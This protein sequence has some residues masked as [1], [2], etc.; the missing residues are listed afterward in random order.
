MIIT[1]PAIAFIML[2]VWYCIINRFHIPIFDL[3]RF[4]ILFIWTVIISSLLTLQVSAKRSFGSGMKPLCTTWPF[5]FVTQ[6]SLNYK[7]VARTLCYWVLFVFQYCHILT[8]VNFSIDGI[9]HCML[10]LK[11]FV[12]LFNS[13]IDPVNS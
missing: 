13:F 4:L 12:C 5:S 8:S 3:R 7:F 11:F 10:I 2:W 1:Y 6:E 9:K